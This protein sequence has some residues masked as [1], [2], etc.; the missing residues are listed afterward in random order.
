MRTALITA[1]LV[2]LAFVAWVLV[3]FRDKLTASQHY[4]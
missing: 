3:D 1:V 4:R 2:P